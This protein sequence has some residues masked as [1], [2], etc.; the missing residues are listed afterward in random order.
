[1]RWPYTP[2]LRNLHLLHSYTL[3]WHG[4]CWQITALQTQCLRLFVLFNPGLFL[5][6]TSTYLIDCAL[7]YFVKGRSH[8]T[9]EEIKTAH[10]PRHNVNTCFM[11]AVISSSVNVSVCPE[12]SQPSF[13][14]EIF[15]F[16]VLINQ[17]RYTILVGHV[18]VNDDH[19]HYFETRWKTTRTLHLYWKLLLYSLARLCD[20]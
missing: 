3:M 8:M 19:W 13:N 16:L 20:Y 15:F 9:M 6:W 18:M 2:G 4:V 11:S 1:M 10:N 5:P 17:K 12:I 7:R 14:M